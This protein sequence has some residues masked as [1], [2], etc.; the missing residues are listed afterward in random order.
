M[1]KWKQIKVVTIFWSTLYLFSF[2]L[3]TIWL[4]RCNS[5]CYKTTLNYVKL[6]T[7][8]TNASLGLQ[9]VVKF[10]KFSEVDND[11]SKPEYPQKIGFLLELMQ[12]RNDFN[13]VSL[14]RSLFALRVATT[15][16][17]VKW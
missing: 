5:N 13:S 8:Q 10:N 15:S 12:M 16:V 14:I 3:Q 17:F 4:Q 6:Q 7:K 11:K 1:C 2:G 9:K